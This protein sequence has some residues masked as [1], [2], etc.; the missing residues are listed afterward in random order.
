MDQQDPH[1]LPLGSRLAQMWG[2][3]Q[4]RSMELAQRSRRWEEQAVGLVLSRLWSLL[5]AVGQWLGRISCPGQVP[6]LVLPLPVVQL[7]HPPF[8]IHPAQVL[9]DLGRLPWVLG[10][11]SLLLQ[12]KGQVKQLV[13]EGPQG[14][15]RPL[16][17]RDQLLQEPLMEK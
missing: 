5:R 15:P 3:R 8:W 6:H 17:E 12:E 10:L 4:Q 9:L 14:S 16:L 13:T 11:G 2:C 7:Q 1:H